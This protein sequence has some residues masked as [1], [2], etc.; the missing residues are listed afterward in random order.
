MKPRSFCSLCFCLVVALSSFA[1][2]K[3]ATVVGG[4]G[5]TLAPPPATEAKPVTETI[6]GVTLSD[7]Y[8]WLEDQKSPATRAWIDQQ[9]KYTAEYFSQL[10]IR[11]KI[12]SEFS[13]LVRVEQ[14][15]L[16]WERKGNFFF[17]KR[18]PQDNQ[19]S[20]YL[21][22]G[23]HGPDELLINA[24]KLSADQNTSVGIDDIAQDGSL[25][26]YG[27][28]NGGADEEAVRIFD[29]AKH[30]DLP[31]S[32]PSARYFGVQLSP[33]K[34][35]LY[36]SVVNDE[37]SAVYYHKFGAPAKSDKLVFGKSFEGET[38]GPMQLIG[39][40]VTENQRYLLI[41]VENGV[42]AKRVDI[43]AKFLGREDAP[44]RK[45]IHGL[46]NRFMPVN[47]G[48]DLYVMTD[49]GA[50]NYRVVRVD[51]DRPEP[52]HW[53]T[54][55]PEGKDVI[56]G[57]SIVGAKLFVTGLHDV[58]TE[59]RVFDLS[60]RPRG[61]IQYPTLG[62]ASEMSGLES[63]KEGFYSFES[64]IMPETIYHY[65]TRTG[66]TDIFAKPNLP[67]DSSQYEV[68]QVFYNS[69]DG[70]RVPMFIAYKKGLQLNGN[71]PTL[72]TAYGGFLVNITPDFTAGHAWWLEHGGIFAQPNLRGGGEYGEKW[73]EAGMFERKQ[74]VFD[75][76]FAAAQYLFD[77]HYT[78]PAHLA[79][80]GA[81]NGGLLMGAAMT[82]HPEMFGA[83]WCG[84]PLLDM[85]RFQ[86]FLVGK[87]W[88][89]EYGSSDNPEQFPYLLKYS[90][91]QNVHPGTKFPAIVFASGDNDTRVDPLHARKMAALVQ[92][93]NAGN[94]PILLH[95][96]TVTGH[97]SGVS[98]SQAISDAA[99]ELGFLW[100]EVGGK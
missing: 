41:F 61:K 45:V 7:P 98:L 33:D 2:N 73:H 15:S 28:R 17:T 18:L 70:T 32:L 66:K 47:Y 3:A 92:A 82:Q 16:P 54:I 58:V 65:D 96:E 72:M 95:Y 91:Y 53:A 94:R 59:T 1:A 19:A 79:I 35:G 93:D 42:P 80:R 60:G 84:Y 75:D 83:I 100:N 77:N 11:P 71:T 88:T 64:L 99:D 44:V 74:N 6:H 62:T 26:V 37:G 68:K 31:D 40:E 38:F 30:E 5:I 21:R 90:P 48:D 25:L 8:R 76:F 86:K 78:D 52:E 22:H 49:Y 55:V 13:E 20:I 57:I 39:A 36:Y 14:Y 97:S 34:H 51:I 27:V 12:A 50:A 46:D 10:K 87:W 67:F 9:M 23:L 85:I 29:V 69:K 89:S 43:Y 81:S 56:S 24:A 63:S 4:N